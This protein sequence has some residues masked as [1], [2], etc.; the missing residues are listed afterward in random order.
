MIPHCSFDL[1]FSVSD[2]GYLFICLL[3]I[4]IRPVLLTP[5]PSLSF[6]EIGDRKIPLTTD[7]RSGLTFYDQ[8]FYFSV[9]L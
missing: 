2:V 5:L 9:I 1:R 4:C 7:F 6:P 8:R 3:A